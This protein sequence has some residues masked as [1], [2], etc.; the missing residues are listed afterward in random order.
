MTGKTA[1]PRT[2]FIYFFIVSR[3]WDVFPFFYLFFFSFKFIA[4]EVG[5]RVSKI[6]TKVREKEDDKDFHSASHLR[7][8]RKIVFGT[9]LFSFLFSLKIFSWNKYQRI[10]EGRLFFMCCTFFSYSFFWLLFH[11]LNFI[12]ELLCVRWIFQTAEN[13]RIHRNILSSLMERQQESLF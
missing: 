12:S 6:W 11:F 9:K 2:C 13:W 8:L 4:T 10:V 3:Q 5:R 7:N 1:W